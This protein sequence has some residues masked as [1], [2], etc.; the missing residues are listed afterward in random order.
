MMLKDK[1]VD[2]KALP[3]AMQL[4]TLMQL[5]VKPIQIEEPV[6]AARAISNY[7]I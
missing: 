3:D 2:W 1:G 4:K 5:L 7:K 6:A